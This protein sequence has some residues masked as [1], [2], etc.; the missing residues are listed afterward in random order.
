MAHAQWLKMPQ[1]S[2]LVVQ[3]RDI[4]KTIVSFLNS[5]MFILSMKALIK[6][7]LAKIDEHITVSRFR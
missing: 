1:T 5:W 4:V 3:I 2:Y 7:K 6:Y